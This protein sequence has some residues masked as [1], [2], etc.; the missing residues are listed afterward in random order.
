[1]P[2]ADRNHHSRKSV[3]PGASADRKLLLMRI[4]RHAWYILQYALV[5]IAV[6]AVLSLGY[7]RVLRLS[8]TIADLV[9][10]LDKRHRR[11]A[12]DNLRRAFQDRSEEECGRLARE[13]FRSFVQVLVESTYLP[14]LL[15]E[16]SADR[17]VTFEVHPEAREA[18]DSGNGIIFSTAHTGN[19]EL[20]GQ[21][22]GL[23]G[24]PLKSQRGREP[25]VLPLTS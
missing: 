20:T 6:T 4:G 17:L 1:V 15:T 22:A 21:V 12:I 16:A 9:F 2:S 7:D 13:S 8:R 24:I 25:T 18:L 11:R 5:R 10:R 23:N 3:P 14:R 19:W